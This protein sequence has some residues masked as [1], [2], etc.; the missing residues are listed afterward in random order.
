MTSW[1]DRLRLALL[2]SPTLL[3]LHVWILA[4]SDGPLLHYFGVLESFAL[5]VV[6]SF[7]GAYCIVLAISLFT[8]QQR[9]GD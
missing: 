6:S 7:V 8:K 2:I 9:K 3:L 4:A 1:F 5:A